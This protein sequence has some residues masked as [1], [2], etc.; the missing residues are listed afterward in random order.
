MVGAAQEI[1]DSQ[2]NEVARLLTQH[3]QVL[4]NK[5]LDVLGWIIQKKCDAAEFDQGKVSP[6]VAAI[7]SEVLTLI[8][9][10]KV[11]C[12]VKTTQTKRF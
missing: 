11:W 10:V 12:F 2:M 4:L 9:A 8:I 3:Y 6:F 5:I 1:V 7:A